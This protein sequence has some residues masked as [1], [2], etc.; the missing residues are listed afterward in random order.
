[1]CTPVLGQ[2]FSFPEFNTMQG[3]AGFPYL[4]VLHTGA[5][6]WVTIEIF[7]EKEVRVYDSVFLKQTYHTLKQIASIV[8]SRSHKIQIL[9]E[10]VQ[11][12]KNAVDC[13]IYAVAFLT[14]L[15]HRLDPASCQYASSKELRQ[16]L[17]ECFEEGRM[18]PFPS[19]SRSKGRPMIKDLHI[20]CHC[21][22]PYVLEHKMK[23]EVQADEDKHMIQCDLCN[24]WYHITCVSLT[25]DEFREFSKPEYMW[26]CEF[27]GCSKYIQ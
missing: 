2:R 3:Y 8:K 24:N 9:L 22:L 19:T 7:S 4:Q 16:H 17:I 18:S 15:C 13:G 26:T 27:K 5:D 20:Y 12:Q 25:T 11:C 14:D 23:R 1:M 10:K 21:R 6:H